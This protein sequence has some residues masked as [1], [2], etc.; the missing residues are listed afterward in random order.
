MF[1]SCVIIRKPRSTLYSYWLSVNLPNLM[2]SVLSLI[3]A[4]PNTLVEYVKRT[5]AA[6][7]RNKGSDGK[8]STRQLTS[9]RLWLMWLCWCDSV[10]WG[11]WLTM[12]KALYW[13]MKELLKHALLRL[14]KKICLGYRE[15]EEEAEPIWSFAICIS[16]NIALYSVETDHYQFSYKVIASVISIQ[17]WTFWRKLICRWIL[18]GIRNGQVIMGRAYSTNKKSGFHWWEEDE[19]NLPIPMMR[20]IGSELLTAR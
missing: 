18:N 6:L 7:A 19:Q 2:L 14:Y 17:M 13:Q 11:Y 4:K 15:E 3:D 9:W 12:V 10:D 8:V 1:K 5:G 20:W 16:F